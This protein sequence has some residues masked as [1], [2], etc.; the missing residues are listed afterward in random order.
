[1]KWLFTFFIVFILIFSIVSAQTR[2]PNKISSEIRLSRNKPSVYISYERTGK[3]EPLYESESSE[4]IWLRLHNN[5]R[6][7]IIFPSSGAPETH[8]D[9]GIFYILETVSELPK[10]VDVI[11]KGYEL[12]HVYSTF[13][14]R[15]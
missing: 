10:E 14:L 13:N 8:G 5:T 11:P 15:G 1:M 3:R 7:T 12:G 6:W 9:I 2:K 4:G